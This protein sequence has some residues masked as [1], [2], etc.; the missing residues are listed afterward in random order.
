M[1]EIRNIVIIGEEAI[2]KTT[3]ANALLGW[4]I[5]PQSSDDEYVPTEEVASQM[6]TD[7]IRL[8]D[9]PGYDSW[10]NHVPDDVVK[11]VSQAD[12]VIVLLDEVLAEEGFFPAD[13]PDW[14]KHLL[15]EEALLQKLL[16]NTRDLFF[17]IPYDRRE[18]PPEQYPPAQALC[19]ARERFSSMSDHGDAGFFCVEPMKALIGAIEADEEAITQSGILPLKSALLRCDPLVRSHI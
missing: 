15:A 8:T 1:N 19:L 12:T 6:L 5:F 16:E 3:L 13:D 10:W 7:S 9:T 2:G 17:V 4:D 18:S 14:E 11:A